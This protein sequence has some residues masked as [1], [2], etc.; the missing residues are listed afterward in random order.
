VGKKKHRTK[1]KKNR[2]IRAA[3]IKV[4]VGEENR[5]VR[6]KEKEK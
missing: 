6:Q 5:I 3:L 1:N 2:R 4:L